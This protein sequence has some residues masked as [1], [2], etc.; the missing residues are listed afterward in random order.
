M[1]P[2]ARTSLVTVLALASALTLSAC[3]VAGP[4]PGAS[5]DAGASTSASTAAFNDADESFAQLMIPHHEQAIEMS[6]DLLTKDG[7]DVRVTDIATAIKAAQQPEIDQMQGWLT[8]W[9]AEATDHSGMGGMGEGSNGMMS[10]GDMMALRDSSGADA[11]AL[12]LQQMIMHHEG[13]IVM[14]KAELSNGEN[15]EA[16][17]LA[18]SIVTSQT[19]E[20]AEMREL[21]A[22]L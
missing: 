2:T 7:V 19:A 3:A 10:D 9:G 20:I 6:D 15:P 5:G 4:T 14:A 13:A 22:A 21:L 1:T 18:Q 11:G 8:E 12:F 16:Q 17:T